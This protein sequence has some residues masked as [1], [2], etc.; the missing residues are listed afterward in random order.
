MLNDQTA[1]TVE[2]TGK[3]KQFAVVKRS[4]IVGGHKTSVSLED[5][6]WASLKQMAG[7]RGISL[8]MQIEEIDRQRRTS[9]LSSAIRLHVLDHYRNRALSLVMIG[10]RQQ[11]PSIVPSLPQANRPGG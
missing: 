8:S 1:Y 11:S 6:F 4:V 5:D 10:E 9:N 3:Q 7:K 2:A